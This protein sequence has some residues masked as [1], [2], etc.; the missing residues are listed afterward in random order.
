MTTHL[1]THATTTETI[2]MTDTIDVTGVTAI[3]A[4]LGDNSFAYSYHIISGCTIVLSSQSNRTS[5]DA[6]YNLQ[7]PWF[8]LIKSFI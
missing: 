6:A 7:S 5:K 3:I 1:A 8:L 4:D 2:E